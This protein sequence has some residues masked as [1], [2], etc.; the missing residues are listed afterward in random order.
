MNWEK[1]SSRKFTNI[2]VKNDCDDDSYQ[3]FCFKRP[4]GS[5]GH[6]QHNWL[7]YIDVEQ[8]LLANS[9]GGVIIGLFE[10][11]SFIITDKN[12]IYW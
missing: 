11:K 12:I 5:H 6:E 9:E 2:I 3:G 1:L 7:Q 10:T 4:L 8:V